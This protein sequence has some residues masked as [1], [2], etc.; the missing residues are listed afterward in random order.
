MVKVYI[1]LHEWWDGLDGPYLSVEEVFETK[2]LAESWIK[3]YTGI[4]TKDEYKI[5]EW[6][7]LSKVY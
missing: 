3:T 5:E 6:S 1:I 4:F 7:V 2:E